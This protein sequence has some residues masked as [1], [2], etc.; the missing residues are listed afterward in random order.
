MAV[1]SAV[2]GAGQFSDNVEHTLYTCPDGVVALVKG[3]TIGLNNNVS[4]N[5]A[6]FAVAG[7]GAAQ[8]GITWYGFGSGPSSYLPLGGNTTVWHVLEP[9]DTVGCISQGAGDT[10]SVVISGAE[11]VTT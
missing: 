6:I 1:R 8:T 3:V 5:P 4:D 11:L 9:G 7:S 10:Y 2:L